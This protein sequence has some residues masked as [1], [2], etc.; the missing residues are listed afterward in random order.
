MRLLPF[1]TDERLNVV[2]MWVEATYTWRLKPPT[3]EYEYDFPKS[4][5]GEAEELLIQTNEWKKE[6]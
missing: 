6:E 1:E 4:A 5:L 2:S 3:R